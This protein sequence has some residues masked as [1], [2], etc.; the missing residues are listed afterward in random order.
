M[1]RY[2]SVTPVDQ[3]RRQLGVRFYFMWYYI[4]PGIVALARKSGLTLNLDALSGYLVYF[5]NVILTHI[6]VFL[7]VKPPPPPPR[8]KNKLNSPTRALSWTRWASY[9]T[10]QTH[11]CFS[12]YS[13]FSCSYNLDAFSATDVNF[14]LLYQPIFIKQ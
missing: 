2:L 6:Y 8:K 12:L 9:S 3:L 7:D 14:F 1:S 11:S 10:P 13:R 4:Q 5:L